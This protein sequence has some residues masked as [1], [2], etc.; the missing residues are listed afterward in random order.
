MGNFLHFIRQ[1]FTVYMFFNVF[2]V[3]IY[4]TFLEP[5]FLER[6]GLDRDSK[7]CQGIGVFYLLIAIIALILR[8]FF[9]WQGG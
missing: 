6:K 2:L 7:L 4:E 9:S 8:I 5:K 1:Y 3:G